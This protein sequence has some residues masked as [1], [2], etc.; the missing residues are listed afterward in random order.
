M[1]A[2]DITSKDESSTKE[3]EDEVETKSPS[4]IEQL[5]ESIVRVT[6]AGF[7]AS[8]IGLAHERRGGGDGAVSS[9]I[10]KLKTRPQSRHRVPPT[11]LMQS[12]KNLPLTWAL[13]SMLFV[14]VLESCRFASPTTILYDTVMPYFKGDESLDSAAAHKNEES[15]SFDYQKTALIAFGD[16]AIGGSIAGLAGAWGSRRRQIPGVVRPPSAAWLGWGLGTGLL[17]GC[18]AGIFQAGVEVGNLYISQQE[19]L[20]ERER[21][22]GETSEEAT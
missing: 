3:P 6:L 16:Y 22:V 12:Q 15:A 17:L 14:S 13:S 20:Q 19:Q 18:V 11:R 9:P 21:T 4:T 5:M 7:A 2:T 1:V 8:T 10:T